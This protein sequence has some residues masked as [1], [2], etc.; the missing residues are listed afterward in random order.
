M[1]RL[2]SGIITLSVLFFPASAKALEIKSPAFP[3]G[4]YL[5]SQYSCDADNISP[6]F[7]WSDVPA[8][9]ESFVLIC[10]DP[11]APS[12]RWTH[13]VIFNIPKDKTDLSKNIPQMGALEDGTIQGVNDFG[14][15]GYSGPCPPAG[16][17]HRYFFKL[18]ALDSRLDL[19]EN[20]TKAAV[21]EAIKG[22]VIAEAGISAIYRRRLE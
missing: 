3:D 8:G 1:E 6:P 15:A 2:F 22:H 19:N 16:R 11:D 13:W 12:K 21:L 7:S 17:A 5:S 20:S 4:A 14:T 9:T 10:D 18:Y